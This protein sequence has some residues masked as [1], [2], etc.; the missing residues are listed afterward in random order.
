[1]IRTQVFNAHPNYR[2]QQA[3]IILL[4]RRVLRGEAIH[5]AAINVIFVNN[6]R[7]IKLNT[8]Y[9]GHTYTTDVISFPL[10]EK[11]NFVEG[12]IYVNLDRAQRQAEEFGISFSKEITRLVIHGALHLAGYTDGTAHEKKAMTERENFYLSDRK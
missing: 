11:E 3:G 9:L 7:M 2:R 10:A 4:L 12:E 8:K 6:Q 1:M 5:N